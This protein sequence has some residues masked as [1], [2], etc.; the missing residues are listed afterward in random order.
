M[1]ELPIRIAIMAAALLVAAVG[2]GATVV[3][4]C[5]ALYALLLT[6]LSAP[7][8]ALAAA[9]RVFLAS[10]LVIYLGS[11]LSSLI[12][13]RARHARAKRGGT[14]FAFSAEL[15]KLLGEDA[16][17]F[18]AGKPI[19]AL[20]VALAGGFAVGVSPR[21]RDFLLRLLKA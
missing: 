13:G 10:L 7:L 19:L 17:S 1:R 5:L 4:L 6:I 2:V 3:F 14:A 15:G 12:A 20:L 8:A 21:L 11:V 16:Q 9:G 18:I